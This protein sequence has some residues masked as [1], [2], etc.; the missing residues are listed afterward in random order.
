MRINYRDL[1][2]VIKNTKLPLPLRNEDGEEIGNI[3]ALSVK[4]KRHLI[5]SIQ[6]KG[7]GA[8]IESCVMSVTGLENIRGV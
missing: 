1:R 8:M 4:K 6:L 5:A 2:K 3:L 7:S